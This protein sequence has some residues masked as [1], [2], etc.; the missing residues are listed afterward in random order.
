RL[1]G[2]R[3]GIRQDT[4][5]G[6]GDALLFRYLD[7]QAKQLPGKGVIV[8][9]KL[10]QRADMTP[11]DNEYVSGR[12]ELNVSEGDGIWRFRDKLRAEL[13]ADDLAEHALRARILIRHIGP[14][15]ITSRGTIAAGCA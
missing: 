11:R 9:A 10:T 3:P 14:L 13:A 15:R 2:V 12:L 4:E 8:R 6:I 5:A 7:R 1:A